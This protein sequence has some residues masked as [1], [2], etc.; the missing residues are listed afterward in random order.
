MTRT[1]IGIGSNL[2]DPERQVRSAIDSLSELPSTHFDRSSGLY[3]TAAWGDVHQPDFINAV[4][5]LQT[6]LTALEL[7]AAV[8]SLENA[9]GRVRDP[10]RP[11]GPRELDLDILWFG[12]ETIERDD[13]LIPHPR[14]HE[15]AFVLQPLA[16]LEP[17][18]ELPKH[19]RVDVLLAG[20]DLAG[21]RRLSEAAPATALPPAST[22]R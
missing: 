9:A 16:E 20:M 10:G 4:V 19:G 6:G 2:D 13:L 1:F 5:E 14:M 8:Q 22:P 12:G 18:L 3:R 11:W 21:I 17:M 15:R 7:L